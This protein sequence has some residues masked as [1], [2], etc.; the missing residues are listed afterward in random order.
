[1]CRPWRRP[2]SPPQRKRTRER[3]ARAAHTAAAE[4]ASRR[5][6]S[7]R[8]YRGAGATTGCRYAPS[9]PQTRFRDRSHSPHWAGHSRSP[10]RARTFPGE[11][12]PRLMGLRPSLG[13]VTHRRRQTRTST[14]GHRLAGVPAGMTGAKCSRMKRTSMLIRSPPRH[15]SGAGPARPCRRRRP[16]PGRR[17]WGRPP[18]AARPA[19]WGHWRRSARP[20]PL[21]TWRE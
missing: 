5:G 21:E 3:E 2:A 18:P 15:R 1:M 19:A 12:L 11:G 17:S 9:S 6:R 16:R 14:P 13:S 10:T 20:Y 7:R 4:G 8:A